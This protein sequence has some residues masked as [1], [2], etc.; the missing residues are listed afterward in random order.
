MD[1]MESLTPMAVCSQDYQ[2]LVC[3]RRIAHERP[4]LRIEN[5][6]TRGHLPRT[7]NLSCRYVDSSIR[8]IVVNLIWTRYR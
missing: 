3:L 7:T 5:P 8:Y 2:R 1:C 6:P 4:Y